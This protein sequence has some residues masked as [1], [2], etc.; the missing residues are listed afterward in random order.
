MQKKLVWISP[1]LPYNTVNHAGGKVL[2]YYLNKLV[3]RSEFDIRI[4][5]FYKPD[6]ISKFTLD[7]KVKCDLFCYHNAGI[8]K[9]LRN[10]MDLNS[11]KN[12]F[13]KYAN[14]TTKYLELNILKTLKRYKSDD[15]YPEYIILDGT[16]IMFYASKIR[17]IFPL[18]KL[19]GIEVDVSLLSY[20]RRISLA[21]EGLQKKLAKIRYINIERE[22]VRAI[23]NCNLVILN[24]EKDRKLLD[25]YH[26]TTPLKVWSVYYDM[27]PMKHMV[28]KS[29]CQDVIF[30][31]AM[32]RVENYMTAQW[33]IEKVKPLLLD[34]N[35]R[36]VI[37]GGNPPEFLKS[38]EDEKTIITGFVDDVTTYFMNGLCMAAPLVLGAGIKIKILEAFTS[39][40]IVLTNEIGIEGIPG[41]DGVDYF[42][43]ETPEE[44]ANRIKELIA[45]KHDTSKMALSARQLVLNNFNYEKSSADFVEWLKEIE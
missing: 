29:D 25:N 22:E 32:S 15:Y 4:L 19:I 8:K 26:I 17:E 5:A 36:F 2:N 31:G 35:V 42:F 12:P 3:D 33:L 41:T 38:Y 45:G 39:G 14:M 27:F 40:L 21:K 23:N 30:Y 16:Q 44:Y 24:N 43:C 1:F 37:V 7:Q 6:E 34:T 10:L 20:Q 28:K 11:L 18:A 13:N 9:I